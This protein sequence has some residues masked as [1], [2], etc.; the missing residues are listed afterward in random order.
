MSFFCMTTEK[1]DDGR[2]DPSATPSFWREIVTATNSLQ[3]LKQRKSFSHQ[4]GAPN[5]NFRKI[6]VR[7][8]IWDQNFRNVCCK[9][10]CLPA[11]PRIFEHLKNGKIANFYRIFTLKRSPRIFGSL[12]SGWNFRQGKFR[13]YNFRIT[14]LSARKSEQ[15]KNF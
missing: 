14:R 13:S 12:F 3:S 11:S 5:D 6:S 10:S 2:L 15:M 9:T 8:T 4:T 1:S 7:K